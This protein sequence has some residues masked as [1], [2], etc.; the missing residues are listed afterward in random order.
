[1]GKLPKG[2]L[3]RNG[4]FYRKWPWAKIGNKGHSRETNAQ[5][6]MGM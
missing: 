1:M 3:S 2:A 6:L 5:R 4:T